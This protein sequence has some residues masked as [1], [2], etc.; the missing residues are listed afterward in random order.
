MRDYRVGAG[1]TDHQ[2]HDDTGNGNGRLRVSQTV[3]FQIIGWIVAALLT[4][5]AIT[6]RVTAL[7][8]RVEGLKSDVQEIKLDIKELLRR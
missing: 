8:T 1:M 3:A 5:S 2:R 4:Y 6:N 7:E